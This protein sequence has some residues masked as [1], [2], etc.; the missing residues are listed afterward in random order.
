V[1]N[2]RTPPADQ[3]IRSFL[4]ELES[5]GELLH[6]ERSVA[7]E[8]GISSFL[9]LTDDGPALVFDDVA[10]HDLPVAGNLLSSRA[11]IGRAL[12]VP[13]G[14]VL[15]SLVSAVHR[16]VL[17]V[18][19]DEAPCQEVV[20]PEVRLDRLPVPQF[21]EQETGPYIT[22]GM[23]IARDVI[24]GRGNASFARLKVLSATEAFIGIAPNHHLA[25]M[26]RRAAE[27][28]RPFEIAVVIGAHPAIQLAA[29]LYLDLGDDELE[30]AGA[31]L[32]EPVRLAPA[33]SV[34]LDVPADAELIIEGTLHPD[35]PVHE[36]W[37]SEFHGMYEDY[38]DGITFTATAITRRR[39]A[40]FQVIQPGYFREHLYLAAVPIAA[41]LKAALARVVP[42]VVD[43]AVV[44]SGAGRTQVVVSL[45]EPKRGQPKRAMFACW[46]AVSIV[47]QVTVVDD[48]IDVWDPVQVE[49]AKATRLRA[50]RD[51]VLVEG[52]AADRSEPMERDG[53][54]TKIGFDATRN[55]GDRVEGFEVALP[56]AAELD[57]ART[58]LMANHPEALGTHPW[59]R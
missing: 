4:A 16:P 27:A 10:G 35:R 36:G 13:S 25:R 40:I 58:W 26:A 43:V 47:K 28:G 37:V 48:D 11:R 32:G 12:G 50:E 6:V 52:V 33:V 18:H 9:A 20:E 30:N 34:G 21:F 22:A 54:V 45:H 17:P 39:D 7:C 49:W 1:G 19:V 56:P 5:T 23:I 15:D 53:M 29:C 8:F 57:A 3:S 2:S 31:L 24:T 55:P 14:D 41:G 46:A 44:E 51:L 38:G 42:N 59:V